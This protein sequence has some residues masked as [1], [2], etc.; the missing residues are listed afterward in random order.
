MTSNKF[1]KDDQVVMVNCME[2]D[3]HKDKVWIVRNDSFQDKC[4]PS[5]EVVFLEGFSGYFF[6]DLLKKVN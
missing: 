5:N 3:Y 1:K 4:K 2:A 6:C